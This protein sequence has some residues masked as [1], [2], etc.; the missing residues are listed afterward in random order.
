ML[1]PTVIAGAWV[2][3]N[4]IPVDRRGSFTKFYSEQVMQENDLDFKIAQVNFSV[5]EKKGTTRGLHFQTPPFCEKKI[6]T[7]VRGRVFDVIVDLRRGSRTFL[8][9]VSIELGAGSGKSLFIPAGCAH[10]YQVLEGPSEMLYA[11]SQEYRPDFESGVNPLDPLLQISWP[12]NIEIISDR[13][14]S[15]P[16]LKESFE[17]LTI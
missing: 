16:H 17:G 3:T 1:S 9:H 5:S 6:V 13:D 15:F 10:G 2:L 4:V 12:L 7:C 14:R 11:H 8:K